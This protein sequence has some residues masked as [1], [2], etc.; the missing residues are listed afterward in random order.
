MSVNRALG[1][2]IIV[3]AMLCGCKGPWAAKHYAAPEMAKERTFPVVVMDDKLKKDI[4]IVQHKAEATA[5][6]RMRVYCEIESRSGHRRVIQV[7]TVFRDE[8]DVVVEESTWEHVVLDRYTVKSYQVESLSN[9]AKRY[10]IRIKLSTET[11]P[12]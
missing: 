10:T 1:C 6:G 9:K 4:K 5:D 11:K 12:K 7:Q 3:L 2:S 8:R